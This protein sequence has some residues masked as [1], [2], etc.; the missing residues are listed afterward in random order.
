MTE[1]GADVTLG[2]SGCRRVGHT[3]LG[4]LHELEA[5]FAAHGGRLHVTGL[6]D[7]KPLSARPQVA[8]KK[9]RSRSLLP[10]RGAPA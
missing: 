7:H 5:E 2:L 8:R 4:N 3:E 1:F 9:R 6:D 10:A